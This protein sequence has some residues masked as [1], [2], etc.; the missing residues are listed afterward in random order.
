MRLTLGF[1]LP[2]LGLNPR[3]LGFLLP[4][5]GLDP[6]GL[7]FLLLA[8]DL[9]P[10]SLGRPGSLFLQLCITSG[11]LESNTRETNKTRGTRLTLDLSLPDHSLGPGSLSHL[12][13][14][15]QGTFRQ[16]VRTLLY[17]QLS[18][19]GLDRGHGFSSPGPKGVLITGHAG[20]LLLQLL[21]SCRQGGDPLLSRRRSLHI[22]IA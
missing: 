8:L 4:V 1:L 13:G 10:R 19:K 20:Q 3:G 17:P 6:R 7:S 5:L 11:S 12:E 14:L 18:S 2:A 22:G 16:L 9:D 21:S 15:I